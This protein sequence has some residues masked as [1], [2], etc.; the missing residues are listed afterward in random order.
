MNR[1]ATRDREMIR[2]AAHDRDRVA[3]A[4][5]PSVGAEEASLT[6]RVMLQRFARCPSARGSGRRTT[7]RHSM[8]REGPPAEALVT[9]PGLPVIRSR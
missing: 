1:L 6:P 2:F 3:N 4:S 8:A 7:R 5:V 9:P